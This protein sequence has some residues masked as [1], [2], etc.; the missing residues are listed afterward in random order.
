MVDSGRAHQEGAMP[1]GSGKK[2]AGLKPAA[3]L[4]IAFA[5]REGMD[6]LSASV[7]IY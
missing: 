4:G 1:A 5:F 3:C 7:M 2:T 6:D